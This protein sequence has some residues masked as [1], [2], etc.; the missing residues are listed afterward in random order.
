MRSAADRSDQQH[1][2]FATQG[3]R[4]VYRGGSSRPSASALSCSGVTIAN[5]LV[6]TSL[7]S[8][9]PSGRYCLVK[10]FAGALT[11]RGVTGAGR[12]TGP[13]G[14]RTTTGAGAMTAG[15]GVITGATMT[16][17]STITVGP[18]W[19][20][21]LPAIGCAPGNGGVGGVC[22][23]GVRMDGGLFWTVGFGFVMDGG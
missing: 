2:S 16:S 18:G 3:V 7:N 20:W 14:A 6:Q 12:V 4:G 1:L 13:A 22:G 8:A 21:P 17:R 5:S 11:T 15:S 23:F 9:L 19:W 10:Q